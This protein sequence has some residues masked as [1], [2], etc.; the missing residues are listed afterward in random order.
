[1]HG[2]E[3]EAHADGTAD[4][5]FDVLADKK[6]YWIRKAEATADSPLMAVA[7][8]DVVSAMWY[9]A[10]KRV[11]DIRKGPKPD[12]A[13]SAGQK[14]ELTAEP[15]RAAQQRGDKLA[16]KRQSR[17]AAKEAVRSARLFLGK[18]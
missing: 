2:Y 12:G 10:E 1:M 14:P 13:Y 9:P 5:K 17:K 4:I 8:G 18:P 16:S 3:A 7:N 15:A 11:E 6:T